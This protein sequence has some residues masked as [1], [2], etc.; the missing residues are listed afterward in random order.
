MIEDWDDAYANAEHIPD[1]EAHIAR[2]AEAAP[3]FRAKH[4]P[5]TL[6]YGSHARERID[7]YRP[8][9][10]VRGL[11]VFVHGGYWKSRDRDV[12]SHLAAGPR[13]R[14]WAVAMPGYVLAPEARI[15]AITRG[16]ARAIAAAAAA[17][18]GP[19]RLA[20]HSAGGHLVA[21]QVCTDSALPEAVAARV[22]RVVSIS[23]VHDLRP[24]LRT[25][26]NAELRLDAAEAVA[27]SPAL[28]EPVA[29]ARVHAWVGGAERPEFVRQTALLANIWTGLGAGMSHTAVPGRHHFDVIDPLADPGSD[30]V[31][32]LVGD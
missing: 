24:L 3:A 18:A 20:G 22:E 4:P 15:A 17:V 21:R 5:E 9:G 7:L 14:G 6:S 2:W 30:L 16:V 12:W 32:A 10:P 11:A 23:G 27:E 31:A 26:M 25:A 13:A 28:R 8:E 29:G 1:A 19:V